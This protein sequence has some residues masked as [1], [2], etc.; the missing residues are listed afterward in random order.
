MDCTGERVIEEEYRKN[1]N[2]YLIYLF[3]RATYNFAVPFVQN[4]TVLDFG[5]GSGILGIGALKL[6]AKE[7]WAVDNDPQ[8]LLATRDNAIKNQVDTKLHLR[9]ADEA[10]DFQADIILA[11]IL[12]NPL[13]SLAPLFAAKTITGGKAILS[14]ILAE[15]RDLV[16]EAY[17]TK[18][19]LESSTQNEDWVRLDMQRI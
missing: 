1:S 19:K 12:A 7:V 11:N 8:A 3:H 14:G 2:T 17:C 4:K 5:C 16:L 6:G 9:A 18:F 13:I 15:Q 10:L